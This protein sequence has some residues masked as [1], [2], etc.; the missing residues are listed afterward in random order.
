MG[1]SVSAGQWYTYQVG[2]WV[3]V[4]LNW[5]NCSLAIE[6]WFIIMDCSDFELM[7]LL[8]RFSWTVVYLSSWFV[9]HSDLELM[10]PFQQDSGIPIESWFVGHSDLELMKMSV[11]AGQWYTYRE[12]VCGSQWPWTDETVAFPGKPVSPGEWLWSCR[13]TM[14]GIYIGCGV[15]RKQRNTRPV[16]T[17]S[18]IQYSHILYTKTVSIQNY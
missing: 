2:L 7:T 3:T 11:S 15:A 9:G 16:Q 1:W 12:L 6:S 10:K 14:K 17:C 5:W 18:L 4:T 8:V 13:W